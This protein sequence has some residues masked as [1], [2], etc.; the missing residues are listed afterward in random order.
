[1]QTIDKLIYER[2]NSL[3]SD[4]VRYQEKID[5]ATGL[6][7]GL[8][9]KNIRIGLLGRT[10]SGKTTLIGKLFN[11]S[12][13]K[14]SVW[15]E[16]ACLVI[17][18]FSAVENVEI[19]PMER[20]KF[21]DSKTCSAFR[22]FLGKF[23]LEGAFKRE[24]A[25]AYSPVDVGA[26]ITIEDAQLELKTKYTILDFFAEVNDFGWAFKSVKW[27][28][29]LP[30]EANPLTTKFDVYD[31]PG[32]GGK[33]EH[34]NSI[35]KILET[36]DLDAMIYLIATD[37]G[38]PS[39]D[40]KLGLELIQSYLRK[41]GIQ[42]YWAYEIPKKSISGEVCEINLH[43]KAED[44][45]NACKEYGFNCGVDSPFL[46][47]TKDKTDECLS[48]VLN[49]V[50]K[51]YFVKVCRA[52]WQEKG[53]GHEWRRRDL[54]KELFGAD[55]SW[56]FLKGALD[57]LAEKC[58]DG[59]ISDAEAKRHVLDRLGIK[60]ENSGREEKGWLGGLFG[61]SKDDLLGLS[62]RELTIRALGRR[63]VGTIDEVI[64]AIS[65]KGKISVD[66]I[67]EMKAKF[68]ENESMRTL[69]YD[70]QF[71]TLLTVG[72]SVKDGIL[73]PVGESLL[74]DIQ[75]KLDMLSEDL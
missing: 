57:E 60:V 65:R 52:F 75:R 37:R 12:P 28:H 26:V 50:L 34:T 40:E 23:N 41:T 61:A 20:V 45:A 19:Q 70:A 16:T 39:V 59:L 74:D 25:N 56:S 27:N 69:V 6:P 30:G 14:R 33:D 42:F 44:V 31:L 22:E 32:F 55:D 38:I 63:I 53:C 62:D 36:T 4:V 1:M 73:R 9:G 48:E 24:G 18:S 7:N 68:D 67:A 10:S 8:N 66:A 43:E 15:P 35:R 11:V 17:H 54:P 2:I 64:G 49:K 13:G 3:V 71:Y 47:L 5:S 51:P 46:D 21:S 29:E 72:E 58:R